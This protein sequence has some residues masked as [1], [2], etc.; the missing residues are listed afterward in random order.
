MDRPYIFSRDDAQI[1]EFS[2][3]IFRFSWTAVR[4]NGWLG[5]VNGYRYRGMNLRR[6]PVASYISIHMQVAWGDTAKPDHSGRPTIPAANCMRWPVHCTCVWCTCILATSSQRQATRRPGRMDGIMG[7]PCMAWRRRPSDPRRVVW[8]ES[9]EGLHVPPT[10]ATWR[11]D[12]GL[13]GRTS[14]PDKAVCVSLSSLPLSS[15]VLLGDQLTR[16]YLHKKKRNYV[17]CVNQ[18]KWFTFD[19]VSSK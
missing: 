8:M 5:I 3:Y 1:K 16:Y 13:F 2:L 19:Q 18:S 9:R 12:Y 4:R 10:L 7:C 17:L 11:S 14:A 6:E 15:F